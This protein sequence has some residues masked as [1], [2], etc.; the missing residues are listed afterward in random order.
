MCKDSLAEVTA[1]PV[2]LQ[3]V[4]GIAATRNVLVKVE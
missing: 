2:R 1:P 3:S 4:R